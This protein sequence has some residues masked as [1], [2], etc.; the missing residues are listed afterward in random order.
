VRRP[1]NCA[2]ERA[3]SFLLDSPR[4]RRREILG[5]LGG[6]AAAPRT[7]WAQGIPTPVAGLR[8]PR[9]NGAINIPPLRRLDAADRSP[10]IEPDLVDAQ[11]RALYEL[12]F[13]AIRITMSFERFGPDFLA[14]IPYV[15]AARALGLDVLALLADFS[16]YD[17]AQALTRARTRDEV[18]RTIV[19]I[20]GPPPAPAGGTGFVGGLAWQVLN[21]PAH[22]LGIAP[23][24][25]VQELLAPAYEDL[26]RLAPDIAVVSAAEI[27]N[28][29][30]I[31]RLRVMQEAGVEAYCDRIGYHVYGRNLLP[32]LSGLA[33]KPAWVTE[34]GAA[35][36][37]NH[38]TWQ[39]DVLP[40]VKERIGNVERV[41]YFALYEQQ[42]HGF[43][44]L[45]IRRGADGAVQ[46]IA[47]SE[48]LA[49]H[50]A[51]RVASE[52]GGAPTVSY[53]QLVPDILAYFATDQDR[54][55]IAATSYGQA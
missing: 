39:R 12:G 53:R 47:E 35:G 11:M 38:L 30:G 20:L 36:V 40:E 16:G 55:L 31:A 52:T 9:V 7:L 17:L 22:F 3:A 32:H 29:D 18:L 44:L 50:L 4:M 21:E 46:V 48:A 41:Y 26:K 33:R 13:A 43:R 28:L 6:V 19:G 34:S 54:A 23:E 27:G 51:Q 24:H 1:P 15:R 37:P 8:V 5:L 49:R 45:D 10:G 2:P 14:A 42:P 25:Y